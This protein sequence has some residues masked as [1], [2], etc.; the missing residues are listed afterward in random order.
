MK[1]YQNVGLEFS[2]LALNFRYACFAVFSDLSRITIERR[3]KPTYSRNWRHSQ[4]NTP[5]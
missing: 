5:P 2:D 1:P 4:W 3:G